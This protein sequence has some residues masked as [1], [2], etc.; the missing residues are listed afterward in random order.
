MQ[1]LEVSCAVRRVCVCVCVCVCIY[2]Y[3]YVARRQ[4]VNFKYGIILYVTTGC[5]IMEFGR[6]YDWV[7]LPAYGTKKCTSP[8]LGECCNVISVVL[9]QSTVDMWV[10]TEDGYKKQPKHVAVASCMWVSEFPG[11]CVGSELNYVQCV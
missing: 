7:F 6:K 9:I 5:V 4:R 11:V 8:H 2:I 1:R 3:I 10:L